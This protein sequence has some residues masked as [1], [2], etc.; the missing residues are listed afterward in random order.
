MTT[1]FQFPKC[2]YFLYATDRLENSGVYHFLL[3]VVGAYVGCAVKN[4]RD[5]HS[6]FQTLIFTFQE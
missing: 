4:L 5:H 6:T 2:L 3:L 1:M